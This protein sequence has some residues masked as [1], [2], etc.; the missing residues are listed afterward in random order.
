M[1]HHQ[2]MLRTAALLGSLAAVAHA[3]PRPLLVE[4]TATATVHPNETFAV[5]VSIVNPGQTAAT[6]G[7]WLCSWAEQWKTDDPQIVVGGA[8]CTK[9]FPT[10]I[11]IAPHDRD[12]RVLQAF[13]TAKATPGKH[14]V[15]LA[16]TAVDGDGKP[17][18]DAMWTGK[19]TVTVVAA[20]ADVT[21]T[22]KGTTFTLA[23]RTAHPIEVAEHLQLQRFIDGAWTDL[24]EA[25]ASGCAAP[26]PRCVTIAAHA[27]LAHVW[28]GDVCA[29]C[30]CDRNGRAQ[31][32]TYRLI[33]HACDG[34]HDFVGSE[35]ALPAGK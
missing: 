8:D 4:A 21:I 19:I 28:S 7:I 31:P 18:G 32:G 1:I 35:I 9:N 27:S 10:T 20:S 16:F 24:S 34:S 30:A 33:A 6:V 26:Q 11:S 29:Q 13:A 25:S 2:G 15:R 22:G 14:D 3:D 5:S 23:N 12:T 17:R